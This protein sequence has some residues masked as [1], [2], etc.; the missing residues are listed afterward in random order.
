MNGQFLCNRP[1]TVTYVSFLSLARA[2]PAHARA[3]RSYAYKK[4]SRGERHGTEAERLLAANAKAD[5]R[6]PNTLFAAGPGFGGGPPGFGGGMG[7]GYAPQGMPPGMG[8]YGGAPG[9]MMPPPP[10][11]AAGLPPGLPPGMPPMMPPG[12]PPPPPPPGMPPPPP[13]PLFPPGMP[14]PPP[15]PQ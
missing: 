11:F 6:G 14:P 3:R 5:R 1:V 12:M 13:P 2:P 9:M 10:P 15:P 4:D 7:G 8:G